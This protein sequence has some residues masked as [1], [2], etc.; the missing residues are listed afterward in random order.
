MNTN[1]SNKIFLKENKE[2]DLPFSFPTII[3]TLLCTLLII[4]STFTQI[5]MNKFFI[6][7]F[8]SKHLFEIY[9]YTELYKYI[10]Q[11]PVI[12]FIA[13]F[14]GRKYGFLSVLL[15]IVLGMFVFPV[16]AL[17][18]GVTYIFQ[19]TFGFILAF[20]IAVFLA[21]SFTKELSL[22][23]AIQATFLAVFAIH[24]VGVLYMMVIMFAKHESLDYMLNWIFLSS[25]I[26]I[27]Y[28]LI[29]GFGAIFIG[30]IVKKFFW[31]ILK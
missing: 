26:K 21:G 23:N 4:I 31:M 13:S 19:Y 3:I 25:G 30:K 15:Y 5:T 22:L 27:F 2:P 7:T 9:D 14:L 20:L 29:Y 28:D 6:P 18:S 8:L 10:P 16:F 24:I 17:G 1:I 11:V 12:L